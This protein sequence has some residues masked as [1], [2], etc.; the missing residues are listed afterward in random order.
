MRQ[1]LL[2]LLCVAACF[3]V[4]SYGVAPKVDEEYDK[5]A[6][7]TTLR[8]SIPI[9]PGVEGL[10]VSAT[11]SA[12]VKGKGVV[13]PADAVSLVIVFVGPNTDRRW[14]RE[15]DDAVTRTLLTIVVDGKG[16]DRL[17]PRLAYNEDRRER[18]IVLTLKPEPLGRLLAAK[19][20]DMRVSTAD[21]VYEAALGE[22]S[23]AAIRELAKRAKMVK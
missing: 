14:P 7:T 15:Y 5:F 3:R 22:D 2:V 10:T 12:T 18:A 4:A 9:A 13:G 23:I 16:R 21:A 19:K 17:V 20:I 11:A 6:D 1:S 8:A